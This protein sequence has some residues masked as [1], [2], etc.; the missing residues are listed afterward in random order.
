MKTLQDFLTEKG[1]S[2]EDFNKKS[3][4][5]KASLYN[6]LNKVNAEAFKA[7]KENT[8]ANSQEVKD[9]I[10]QISKLRLEQVKSLNDSIKAQGLAI[11]KISEKISTDVSLTE[12]GTIVEGLKANIDNLL[13]LKNGGAGESKTGQFSFKVAGNMT[14]TG[15]VSGGNVPVE[16]RE[17][18]VNRIARRRTFIAELINAGVATSNLISWV[19]QALPDGVAGGT[20]EGALKNQIDFD[21]VVKN[22]AVK[23]RTAFIKVSTEMLDDVDFM[24]SEI[25][26][27]LMVRL[28]L[29]VD[30]QTLTGNNVGQNLNG[31]VTQQTPFA[32]GTFAV[33]V[34]N[35]NLVDVLVV[36]IDQIA[37]ANHMA[38]AIV[39]NGRDVTALKLQKVSATDKRYIDRLAIIAGQLSLDGIPIYENNGM[40]VGTFLV[41][42][43]TKATVF[44]KGDIT[45]DFNLDSDD[46][47]K[48]L[49]TVLAEWRGLVR[50]KSNDATAFV[51]GNIA[52]SILAIKAP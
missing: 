12:K 42:D 34:P 11:K 31:L 5:E 44:S 33:S 49:R 19:E 7:L 2:I 29:D 39:L 25:D 23:K 30:S 50:I 26:N 10:E 13:K 48:N 46:F 38:S 24:R 35:A 21:L 45:I 40:T 20:A 17:A 4:D 16:Q 15:N 8:D 32:A 41:M 52:T 51:G 27:E 28:G 36:A 9:A 18:G 6:E 14:L 22:E 1:I 3:G 37:A 43:G 47:T